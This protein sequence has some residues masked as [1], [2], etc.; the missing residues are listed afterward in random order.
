MTAH[1][2]ETPAEALDRADLERTDGPSDTH[3]S[4]PR[5]S[6]GRSAP[7]ARARPR[8]TSGYASIPAGTW[9]TCSV[10]V[11]SGQT[12]VRH[13]SQEPFDSWFRQFLV[14]IYGMDLSQ[15]PAGSPP[16]QLLSWSASDPR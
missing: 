10:N 9:A 16:E 2:A 4:A 11:S 6:S 15:P 7:P 1:V 3:P 8:W 13:R 14:E 5:S 12:G